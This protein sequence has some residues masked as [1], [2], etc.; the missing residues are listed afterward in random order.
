[1]KHRNLMI[2]AVAGALI[3]ANASAALDFE[4]GL[5]DNQ[6]ASRL[7]SETWGSTTPS[8]IA[9]PFASY[10]IEFVSP[11]T[12]NRLYI[13]ATGGSNPGPQNGSVDGDPEGFVNDVW[14]TANP[15]NP[16]WDTSNDLTHSL[17]SFFLRGSGLTQTYT[18]PGNPSFGS[19]DPA[20]YINLLAAPSSSISGQIWDIDGV[21]NTTE[22]WVV[23]AFT[24]LNGTGSLLGT[25]TSPS[26][27]V[28]NSSSL[29]GKAWEFLFTQNLNQTQ[30]LK[31]A[32]TG[33]K[34]LGIGVAFDNF[35]SGITVVPVPAAVWLFGSGLLGLTGFARKRKAA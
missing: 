13:E 8:S 33:N 25:Q 11:T 23:T 2:L 26:H 10:N 31:F 1:M 12:A 19:T 5:S 17:G 9:N 34:T 18:T 3:S 35:Q 29:D 7:A 22:Q 27:G 28:N 32:F 16:Q 14:S 20:F 30:S 4:I 24:G 21:N 6:V 15:T